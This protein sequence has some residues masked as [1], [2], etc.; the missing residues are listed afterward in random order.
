MYHRTLF[1]VLSL[2]LSSYAA[3]AQSSIIEVAPLVTVPF[4]DSSELYA[5]GFGGSIQV[6]GAL[7]DGPIGVGARADY[8]FLPLQANAG[9]LS[10]V[11]LAGTASFDLLGLGPI[12]VSP[13]VHAGLFFA[14]AEQGTMVNPAAGAGV[15]LAFRLGE[16]FEFAVRPG[17]DTM[18]ARRDGAITA[19]Y[20]GL[21]TTVSVGLAPTVFSTGERRPRI[22]IQP[23]RLDPV[24]PVIYKNYDVEPFGSVTITNEESGPITS[25]R[26]EFQVPQYMPSPSVIAEIDRMGR[27][28]TLDIPVTAL[29]SNEILGITETDAV[30]GRVIVSY[31]SGSTDLRAER[32]ATLTIRDRNA[33][34]WDDDRKAAAFISGRDPLV[35]RLARNITSV[36][37]G[38]G[39]QAV[40]DNFR[41]AFALLT[42]LAAHGVRYEIDP[43][44]A[45]AELSQ[46]AAV[47]D[48]LQFPSQTLDYRA[49]DCDDLS[50]LYASLL[51]SVAVPAALITI[52]G[53]LYTAF[54]L[55]MTEEEAAATFNSM[56][57]LIVRE[58]RVWVPVE[59]T[60]L[61][62][63]FLRAWGVGASQWREASERGVAELIEVQAAQSVYG[64]TWFDSSDVAVEFPDA[65]AVAVSYERDV[66]QFVRREVDPIVAPLRERVASRPSPSLENR[67]GTVYARYGL[68]NEAERW[69]RDAARDDYPPALVNLGNLSYLG[70]DLR[71]AE[72][73]YSAAG[74]L[75][76]DDP[77]VLIGLARTQFE[78]EQFEEARESYELAAV[79][80][81][82]RAEP[83][84]YIVGGGSDAA[85][86][87]NAQRRTI[88]QW[89]D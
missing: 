72:R 73:Y 23:P 27:G 65:E 71:A 9:S 33:I 17:V 20:T 31:T 50:V 62:E 53:H 32:T 29:F 22:D 13:G 79:I 64:A 24:F 28:E 52:P 61:Q 58:G 30:Q 70:G 39:P 37:S 4:L 16:S 43:N 76:P 41:K 77:D 8:A 47:V 49:G 46:S 45:Y 12:T 63:G 15:R 66:E 21:S 60:L 87:S 25:V 88:M 86:A 1:V 74:E 7:A 38:R 51:E 44:S 11:T 18:I 34:T 78:L 82:V 35:L 55:G 54:D 80:A 57:D 14:M 59:T 56:S 6:T 2:I 69:F 83:F 19:F 84:N 26:V 36:T 42:S 67:I 85:R 81:P 40:N 5:N 3:P 10:L 75:A 48:Y 89:A 68:F